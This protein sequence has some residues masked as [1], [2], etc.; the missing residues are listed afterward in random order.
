M[1]PHYVF[2]AA[3]IAQLRKSSQTARQ[4]PR[5][6]SIQGFP[7]IFPVLIGFGPEREFLSSR[8]LNRS[9]VACNGVCTEGRVR[10]PVTCSAPPASFALAGV[11][12]EESSR[13]LMNARSETS[14]RVF[15][16]LPLGRTIVW[17]CRSRRQWRTPASSARRTSWLRRPRRSWPGRVTAQ[18]SAAWRPR[19]GVIQRT[20]RRMPGLE[21]RA[22]EKVPLDIVHN[23]Q[24][25]VGPDGRLSR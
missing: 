6:A 12:R 21:V 25:M 22:D 15:T 7:V 19:R 5:R 1:L 9:R 24:Y 11:C 2:Q 17:T 14:L 3:W 4:L 20:I 8:A 16:T 23:V 13:I 10:I 18:R